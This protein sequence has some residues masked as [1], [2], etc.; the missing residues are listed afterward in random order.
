[1]ATTTRTRGPLGLLSNLKDPG[2]KGFK[3]GDVVQPANRSRYNPKAESE[4]QRLGMGYVKAIALMLAGS[5]YF[6]GAI[7]LR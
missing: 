1:M 3:R 4:E 5:I 6:S 2:L 7:D